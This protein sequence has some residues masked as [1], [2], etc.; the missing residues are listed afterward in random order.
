M[1]DIIAKSISN[2]LRFARLL[3]REMIF[4]ILSIVLRLA[5]RPLLLSSKFMALVM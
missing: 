4:L 3:M 5:E 1:M 2:E